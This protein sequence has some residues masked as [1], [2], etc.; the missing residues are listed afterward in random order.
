M[1]PLSL[2]QIEERLRRLEDERDIQRTM[3]TYGHAIDSG[4]E[5]AFMDCWAPDAILDWPTRDRPM[6]GH[7][8][9]RAAFRWHTHAPQALHKHVM[10]EPV[11]D[12]HGDSAD[13]TSMF[14]RF[15][16]YGGVP[17]IRIYGRYLDRLTRC[18]DGKWRFTHRQAVA[19]VMRK[20]APDIDHAA[21]QP[22]GR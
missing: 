20:E 16:R 1:D 6:R 17:L 3:A 18:G 10:V 8:E 22:P 5:A 19:E 4:D 7:D 9:I 13:V 15:D 14:A 2:R 12:I 21:L 11:I